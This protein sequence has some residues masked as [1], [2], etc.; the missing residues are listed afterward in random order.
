MRFNNILQKFP[1]SKC[2]FREQRGSDA[3]S[4]YESKAFAGKFLAFGRKG[5]HRYKAGYKRETKAVQFVERSRSVVIGKN[6]RSHTGYV[7]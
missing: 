2:I 6:R 1:T 4:M 5:I 3:Y 7:K